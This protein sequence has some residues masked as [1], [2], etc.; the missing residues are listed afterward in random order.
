M[1][2]NKYKKEETILIGDSINDF[3]AAKNNYIKFYGYNNLDLKK[4]HNYIVS[5]KSLTFV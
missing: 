2:E 4:T 1:I 5:F 3:E